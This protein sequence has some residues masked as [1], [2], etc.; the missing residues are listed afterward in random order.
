[1]K[2][3]LVAQNEELGRLLGDNARVTWFVIN[4]GK[5]TKTITTTHETHRLVGVL[6]LVVT[7]HHN[8]VTLHKIC[9]VS[10]KVY[11]AEVT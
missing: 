10:E 4:D 7:R 5:I 8:C 6:L 2:A 11:I 9:Q 1:M 3:Y